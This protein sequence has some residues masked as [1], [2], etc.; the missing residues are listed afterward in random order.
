MLTPFDLTSV[1]SQKPARKPSLDI[2]SIM[3]PGIPGAVL[4]AVPLTIV[5]LRAATRERDAAARLLARISLRPD[6]RKIGFLDSTTTWALKYFNTAMKDSPDIHEGL[7]ML[8]FLN[9]LVASASLGEV[10]YLLPSIYAACQN[11]SGQASSH[12][13]GASA[14]GRKFIVKIFR[15]ILSLCLKSKSSA[16]VFDVTAALE[17]VIGLLL[18]YLSDSDTPVRYAAS[19]ALSLI[20]LKLDPGLAAE[21]VEAILGSLSED[22]LW[23]DSSR[24]T[25]AVNALRWHGLILTLSHLLFRRAPGIQQLPDILNALIVALTFEQ[26]SATGSSQGTNVRDAACFGI[27]SLSR[28]YTTTELLQ[29]QVGSIR[30]T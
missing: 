6:M 12:F 19:K 4:R 22:V 17:E 5:C 23:H 14:V 29:V 1:S 21:V 20:T 16:R 26:R 25:S 8:T 27:W 10:E 13:L 11:I 3:P 7:G 30:A 24:D 28:R 15:N 18:E 2:S 9:R